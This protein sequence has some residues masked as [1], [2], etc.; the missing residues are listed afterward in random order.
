MATYAAIVVL[1]LFAYSILAQVVC[2]LYGGRV[3][4]A[5]GGAIAGS[6]LSLPLI[7]LPIGLVQRVFGEVRPGAGPPSGWYVIA[8]TC[9]LALHAVVVVTASFSISVA[10]VRQEQS[11]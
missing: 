6:T 2:K 10:A 1:T 7:F 4:S 3:V 8:A 5:L 11:A 9:A